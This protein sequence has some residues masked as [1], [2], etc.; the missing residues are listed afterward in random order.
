MENKEAIENIEEAVHKIIE[1]R[2]GDKIRENGMQLPQLQ[3][4]WE[5]SNECGKC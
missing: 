2:V 4:L 3:I 5:M 1:E